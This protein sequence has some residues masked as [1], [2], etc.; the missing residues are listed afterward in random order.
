MRAAWPGI[1]L[2]APDSR[3]GRRRGG[4]RLPGILAKIEAADYD[5]FTR[6]A[7]LTGRDKLRLLPRRLVAGPRMRREVRG[8][9]YEV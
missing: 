5:V 7:H 2:L 1:A 9:R 4:H 6:R 8:T 3:F